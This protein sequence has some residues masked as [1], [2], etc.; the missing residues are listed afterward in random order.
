MEKQSITHLNCNHP[1]ADTRVCLHVIDAD[2]DMP[3]GDIVVR[4]TDTDILVILLHHLHRVT[5]DV[6]MDVGTTGRG[7]RRYVSISAIASGIG[8]ES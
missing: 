5:S 7:N 2:R 4:A 1:E 6:W 3:N 8:P